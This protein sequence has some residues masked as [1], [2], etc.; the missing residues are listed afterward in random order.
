[1][2][3]LFNLRDTGLPL[4]TGAAP[5]WPWP[6]LACTGDTYN[7]NATAALVAELSASDSACSRRG[8]SCAPRRD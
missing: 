2:A 7:V 5:I 8:R 3:T 1:M 6:E 4:P